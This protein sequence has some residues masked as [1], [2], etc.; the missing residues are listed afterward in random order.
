MGQWIA[1]LK[2]A[3]ARGTPPTDAELLAMLD[4]RSPVKLLLSGGHL[5]S[6]VCQPAEHMSQPA[7]RLLFD[8]PSFGSAPALPAAI[9]NALDWDTWPLRQCDAEFLD[10]LKDLEG[11][12]VS[13]K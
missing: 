13:I 5:K 11:L 6:D 3:F 1:R 2:P 8:T 4:S 10:R 12:E 7:V 9:V